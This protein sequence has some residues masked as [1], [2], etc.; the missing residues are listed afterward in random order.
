[1]ASDVSR[2]GPCEISS[3]SGQ[4][5]SLTSIPSTRRCAPDRVWRSP[6]GLLTCRRNSGFVIPG[7]TARPASQ[8]S[9]QICQP[10]LCREKSPDPGRNG[11]RVPKGR[12]AFVTLPPRGNNVAYFFVSGPARWV[13]PGVA[14]PYLPYPRKY[15][16]AG[17]SVMLVRMQAPEDR[18]LTCRE[19]DHRAAC[20]T[21]VRLR[22]CARIGVDV[23]AAG[24][25]SDHPARMWPSGSVDD[26]CG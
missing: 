3:E 6:R 19:H 18:V 22:A 11:H 4:V 9:D 23:P 2:C 13:A 26:R 10:D 25:M 7:R 16:G 17:I 8:P 24:P 21:E 15:R 20:V 12:D 14:M 5:V 1:M